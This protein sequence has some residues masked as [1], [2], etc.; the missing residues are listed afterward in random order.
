MR[1]VTPTQPRTKK[2]LAQSGLTQPVAV[3]KAQTEAFNSL[4]EDS[5]LQPDPDEE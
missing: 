1:V 4:K 3:L 5:L 2:T